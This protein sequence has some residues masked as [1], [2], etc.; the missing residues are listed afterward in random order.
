MFRTSGLLMAATI[1][2]GSSAANAAYTIKQANTTAPKEL[3]EP[4]RNLMG[5]N[6]IQLLDDK[7]S[8]LSEL[9]FRKDVPSKATPEQVKNGLTYRELEEST[10]VGAIRID[11]PTTDYRK[12]KI[13]PG[14]YTLRLGFQPMD[15]DHM[16]TAPYSEF[17][18][19]IPANVDQKPDRIETKELREESAKSVGAS[20]PGVLLLY[21]NEKPEEMPKLV[22]KGNDTWVLNYKLPVSTGDKTT[23]ASLGVSLTL[24]GHSAME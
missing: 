12:Q 15:G 1:L 9:W 19:L 5:A 11:Q 16:G 14:V 4:I 23:A 17:C 24:I 22:D 3:S 20:H 6:S 21:P 2:A 7:G 18:L 13:K 10:L 8:L